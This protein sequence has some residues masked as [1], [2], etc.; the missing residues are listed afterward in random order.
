VCILAANVARDDLTLALDAIGH[1]YLLWTSSI[2]AIQSHGAG[3]WRTRSQGCSDSSEDVAQLKQRS[4]GEWYGCNPELMVISPQVLWPCAMGV[5]FLLA[6]IY[7]YRRDVLSAS[8]IA[9]VSALGPVFVAASLAAFAGEHFTAA[10]GI[11]QIVPKWI[12]DPAFIAYFVGV[13]HTAAALSFVSR[14]YVRWSSLLLGIMLSLFVLLMH[15]PNIG[16]SPGLRVPWIVAVRDATFALGAFALFAMEARDR[17]PEYARRLTAMARCF[18]AGVVLYFGIDHFLHPR[19]SPG[20]PDSLPTAAWVPAPMVLAYLIGALLIVLAVSMFLKRYS[21]MGAQ[22]I[23]LV[24]LLLTILLYLPNLFLAHGIMQQVTAL[25][26]V[27]DTLLFAGTMMVI[28]NAISIVCVP[29]E[30]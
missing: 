5:V 9:R 11:A 20:V 13:A 22:G 2:G 28:G 18:S 29:L 8:G 1:R 15:V 21:V 19:L 30:R 3:N 16:K 10:T 24:M 7:T 4:D 14:R 26:F 27:F 23:G 17:W 12:P 6:G 25:N